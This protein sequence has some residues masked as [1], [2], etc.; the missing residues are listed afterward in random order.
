MQARVRTVAFQGIDV[1]PVDVQV[2][3]A[4]GTLAFAMVG[5]AD[6]AVGES[7]ERIRAALRALG[8]ALPPQ[9]ISVNLSP[10]DLAKEGSHYDLP[11]ALG[12][13]AAMGVIAKESLSGY[14]VLGE[15]ALD[16]ALT[17]VPGVLPA[18]IA[19]AGAG[20][21][22]ICP[23]ACGGEAAWGGFEE[24]ANDDRP[25]VLAAP[26]L[27]ALIN[28][29]RGQQ[30]LAPPS[31][32]I[33]NEVVSYPDLAEIKGQETAK[34]V[35][36]VAA[37]GGHNLLMIG[38][39]GSGKSMLAA[40][41]P[42]L[43]PPLEPEEALEATMV[44]S[45][46]GETGDGKLSRRRAF[47]DPHHS[48]TLQALI[49]GGPR[50]RPGEVSLAHHGVLFLD[51]LPEFSRATLEALR[52]P[53]EAGR[54][55]VA[56]AAAHVTYPARFQLVAAMN[57][58]RC[59]HL[60]EPGAGCGRAPRCGLDYQ[61]K[62]SGPLLD[63]IDLAIDVP[64]VA[65]SDLALPPPAESSDDVAARVAAARTVQR[66]RLASLARKGKL[67]EIE[68]EPTAGLLSDL[69]RGW[70][71][72][73]CNADTDG[74]LLAA[75]AEP[76]AEGRA[77]LTRAAERLGLSARAWHR[78]LRVARTLADLDGS[79]AVRRL[80]IAEALSYRR[81]EPRSALA[82]SSGRCLS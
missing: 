25:G 9:R 46:A 12:L 21:G 51:E 22:I 64:K 39:P 71:K 48:A 57:P 45:L 65:A 72:P 53:L 28:H 47:R 23:A 7:R 32:Q 8:L 74:T 13:L 67:T 79:D 19:A 54:V 15:L 66:E 20:R 55:S 6:K 30:S 24:V 10:A 1:R 68:A 11:I 17:R 5:L 77:L 14:V 70:S 40:R 61:G 63:R 35:L 73:R 36:E 82:N 38:P 2:M 50:A 31:A 59:G 75:I 26:S 3:I 76:D 29:L 78:T 81:A 60:M 18:A 56:R 43:L 34:R 44:R 80:H 33:A 4:P 69:A 58:C 49:G 52:Q 41:L 62:L 42:G 27:L 37:A 16:G